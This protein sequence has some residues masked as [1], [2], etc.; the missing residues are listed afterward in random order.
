MRIEHWR[1]AIPL[2]LRG[3]F[4]RRDVERD[5]DDEIRDHI[6]RQTRANIATG[7]RPDDARRAALV[8]FGGVERI[9]DESRDTR[10]ITV[11]DDLAQVRY[12]ARSLRRARIFT[13]ASV[14]TIALAVAVG[15]AMWALLY[16]VLLSP[17]PYPDSDRLVGVWNTFPALH[18]P[19]VRQ[20]EGTFDAYR[21]FSKSFEAIGIFTDAPAAVT[22]A[23]GTLAPDRVRMG[24][25]SASVFTM[26]GAHM[27]IG[28][29]LSDA[30][31][32]PG[33]APVIVI[34]E[35]YWRTRFGGTRAVLGRH[36]RIEGR[37]R[38]IVGVLPSSFA[39]PASDT[40]IWGVV[41][42][43][44]GAYL[45]S[46]SIRA[47][48]R[49]R[50]GVTLA[51]AQRE[52]ESILIRTPTLFP[53]QRPGVSTASVLA[54]T[55]AGVVL[56]S[57]RD[58]AIGGFD[59]IVWLVAAIAAVLVIVAFSNVASLA[60]ARVE[61]R[62]R[63]LAVRST[64]GASPG[65][66]WFGLLA[67]TALV[68]CAGG[69]LG[70]GIAVVVLRLL[71]RLGPTS[72]PD[73]ILANGGAV[74]LPR[75]NE[76]HAG[77]PLVLSSIV[78]TASFALVG[79]AAGAWRAMSGDLLSALRDGGRG[80]TSGRASHRLRG[81]FVAVEVA[82]SVVLLSASLVLGRSLQRLFNV[83]PG[84]DASNVFTTWTALRHTRYPAPE[85]VAR[86]YRTAVARIERIPGVVAAG[87]VSKPPLQWAQT[88][89]VVWVEDEPAGASAL[90]P[91]HPVAEASDGYFRAMGI[92]VIAGRVFDDANVRRGAEEAVVSQAFAAQYWNDSTGRRALGRR[93]RPY[94]V[95]PWLT[96]VGVVGDVR[97]T[98]LTGPPQ[99]AVYL[100]EEP[101]TD[102]V[103]D[104]RAFPV[105]AFVVRTNGHVPDIAAA[106]QRE[107]R[108]VDPNALPFQSELMTETVAKAGARTRFVLML[109][110][111]GAAATLTLGVVGLY[112]VIAY[113]V[114]LRT[115]EIGIRIALGLAPRRA[116]RMILEQGLAII[117]AGAV[118]GVLVFLVFARLLR[119][120][121]FQVSV[122]DRP[123]VGVA[124]LIVLVVASVATWMPARR[125][126]RIDPADAL[127]SD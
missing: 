96:I 48:G 27:L 18:M 72:L 56:R 43:T 105:M 113:L 7:M 41:R 15:S 127:K 108:A 34:R 125:A 42:V 107:I 19:L 33:A 91:S 121:T 92:P 94:A 49:L 74:M 10:R 85:D 65:R 40:Q 52:L 118:A 47:L 63:E 37:D 106:V 22:S 77:W 31:E 44:P 84:F 9:K 62:Q 11:I 117:I 17:L 109:L 99:S 102:T 71:V 116:A 54:Q 4:R 64:L 28:R 80:G 82:L 95:G 2:W 26:L 123:S 122:V 111:A 46:F 75:L 70:A 73:P 6:D 126:A 98:S 58:D 81:A 39:F 119:S 50:R 25:V 87:V 100:P 78:L 67:E 69:L 89:R 83:R 13:G 51:A 86:F 24:V 68:S 93:F 97:D 115:R 16:A 57:L 5:V 35:D 101:G 120:L 90:P 112:G 38:E 12:A 53:E 36:I 3:V 114:G 30:D 23:D 76:V 88:Q 61:A 103:S 104:T 45:G 110:S 60:L 55:K 124:A 8:A 79:G 29:P 1:Y 20:A 32:A 59:R 21:R 14:A 66:I